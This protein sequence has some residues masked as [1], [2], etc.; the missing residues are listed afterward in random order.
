MAFAHC[1][2]L[3]AQDSSISP[4]QSVESQES[5][6]AA[7]D[8]PA[9]N[10][11]YLA[12]DRAS[13]ASQLA[14]ANRNTPTIIAL[15]MPNGEF[16]RFSVVEVAMMEATL[17]AKYPEIKIYKGYNVDR[18][19]TTIR[20]DISPRGF[21]AFILS[22]DSEVRIEPAVVG[23]SSLHLSYY[24]KDEVLPY[25]EAHCGYTPD[26][27]AL[28]SAERSTHHSEGGLLR[29]PVGDEHRTYRIAISTRGDLP[30]TKGWTTTAQVMT[31]VVSLLNEVN[32]IFERD[33]SMT[34]TMVA[35]TDLMFYLDPDTDP[36]ISAYLSENQTNTDLVIGS[37]NYDV[38]HMLKPNSGGLAVLPSVCS[39]SNKAKGY[40][41]YDFLQIFCHELGHQLGAGHSFNSETA[42]CSGN[43]YAADAYEP[44]SGSTIM[45]YSGSCAP[46][47]IPNP[48][49]VNYFNAGAYDRITTYVADGGNCYTTSS[50]GNSAPVVSV[51]AGGFYIPIST[52]FM[53]TGSATDA[54][55]DPLEYSWEQYNLGPAGAPDSPSGDA[56]IFRVFNPVSTPSRT[57]PQ[58]DDIINNTSTLGET[59]PT[60]ARDLTFRLMV[61]DNAAG[62]GGRL[63]RTQ[64]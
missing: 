11:R 10:A 64:F 35:N 43:H 34:F 54:D 14:E 4:W 33:L 3:Q 18:P 45:S 29:T 39:A 7:P 60:Y 48:G 21:H 12:L 17:A 40:S 55:G 56:P 53:L 61:R 26:E 6:S 24:T 28:N 49:D 31:N 36:F 5:I 30:Q 46:N 19:S 9:P 47:N 1:L 15:P 20:L 58:I 51:P 50:T 8:I 27:P 63:W 59:L 22:S 41:S 23:N 13:M 62:G 37:A 2:I 42:G 38:G 44:G 57:F 52:P 25:Q 32:A 16:Q